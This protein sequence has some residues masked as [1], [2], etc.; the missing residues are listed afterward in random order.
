MLAVGV[1][2]S[3]RGTNLQAIIDACNKKM[4]N[5]RVEVVISDNENA[6]AL[7]RARKNGI[8][9]IYVEA[10][11]KR[12]HEEEINRIFEEKNIE[13]IVG[14]GYMRILSPWFINKWRYKIINIHPSLL[15][16]FKGI[17]AQKQALDYGVK[18]AGCTTHFM[19]ELPDHGPIIL[20]AAVKVREDDTR[21]TLAE[22]I[23]KVEHQ[24]LPR[25]IDLFEKKRLIVEGRKVKILPGDTWLNKY[26]YPDVL[27]SEGY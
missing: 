22:R 5:A 12:K 14:A 19:D 26:S 23:L 9:A 18:I 21:D 1:L 16:S 20:Q 4:I 13:L 25:S 6:F 17:D 24:I 8:D 10:K 2:A 27:Y 11:D 3:G 7:E 15:P